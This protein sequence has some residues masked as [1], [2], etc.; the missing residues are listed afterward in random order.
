MGSALDYWIYWHLIHSTRDYRQLKH[1]RWSTQFTVTPAL[2]FSVWT[3]HILTVDLSQSHCNFKSHMKS[4]SHS[5]IP[6]LQSS[7]LDPFLDKLFKRHFLSLYI[8]SGRTSKKTQP[9]YCWECFFIDPLPSNGRH[10]VAHLRFRGC[11]FTES[12]LSNGSIRHTIYI[13]IYI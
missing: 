12:L 5:L 7:E 2:E 1:Y 11:G 10:I 4:Y 13:Y 3:N 9:L 8:S 6:F